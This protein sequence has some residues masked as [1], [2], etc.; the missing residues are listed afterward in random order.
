[1]SNAAKV[2]ALP[3]DL[4]AFAEERVRAG[5]YASVGEVAEEAFRL[6]Q[7]RDERRHE[8]RSLLL[9]FARWRM[10]P[11]STH[12]KTSL[13]K[14]FKPGRWSTPSNDGGSASSSRLR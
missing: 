5:E 4:Q 13:S 14:Q 6:L 3:D 11:T 9:S 1:M 12:R 7:R 8:V 10:A 2:I